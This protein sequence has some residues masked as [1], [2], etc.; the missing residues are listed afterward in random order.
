MIMCSRGL[1]EALVAEGFQLPKHCADVRLVL[2]VDGA[3]QLHYEVF[4][5]G[6]DLAKLGRALE[7]MGDPAAAAARP[8]VKAK[9]RKIRP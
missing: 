4:V 3:V 6:T 9:T 2:P 5:E 8:V 7:R 1:Y